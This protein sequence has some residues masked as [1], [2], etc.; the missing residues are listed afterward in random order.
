VIVVAR[1]GVTLRSDLPA[2]MAALRQVPTPVV[3]VVVLEQKQ[4]D[5]TYYPAASKGFRATPP[6]RGR[7]APADTVEKF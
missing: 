4:I 3:G 1:V 7:P 2:A 6:A 5:E